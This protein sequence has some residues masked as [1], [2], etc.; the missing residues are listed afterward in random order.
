MN[1]LIVKALKETKL[2]YTAINHNMKKLKQKYSCFILFLSM[3]LNL[4]QSILLRLTAIIIKVS[5][6]W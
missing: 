4:L 2:K 1:K 3:T 5:T 6:N